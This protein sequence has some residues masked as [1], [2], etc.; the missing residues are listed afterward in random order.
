M[1]AKSGTTLLGEDGKKLIRRLASSFA[2]CSNEAKTYGAC[3][4]LHYEAVQKS[5][6]E[7]EFQALQAC[8]RKQISKARTRGQ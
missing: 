2:E 7:A 4:K 6:C 5:A 8:F 3:L 1:P